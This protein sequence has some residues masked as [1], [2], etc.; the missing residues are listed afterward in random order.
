MCVQRNP[1]IVSSALAVRSP[2]FRY[3]H[4]GVEK[5]IRCAHA[6]ANKETVLT[7]TT[8]K[9]TTFQVVAVNHRQDLVVLQR[10]GTRSSITICADDLIVGLILADRNRLV[11]DVS[12]LEQR[13]V[14]LFLGL[15]FFF[16]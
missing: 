12:N 7:R 16:L 10:C 11:D 8:R 2:L 6:A 13:L 5:L 15:C 3:A 9:R 14:K 4:S 1:L